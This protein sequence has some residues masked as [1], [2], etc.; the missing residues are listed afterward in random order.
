MTT[1]AQASGFTHGYCAECG[2]H[3]YVG[4]LH[5]ERGGPRCCLLC[6]GK[7]DAEHTPRR[8]ARRGLIRALK[9]YD[10]A[11]GNVYGREFDELKLLA[12]SR[13]FSAISEDFKDLTTELLTA[14]LALTHPDRH[15]PERNAEAQRVT[16]ELTALQPFVFPA[17]EPE[18][19]P[20]PPPRSEP[21]SEPSLSK[22][23]AYPCED[24]RGTVAS[25]Y[26]DACS[27]EH[28]KRS[29]KDFEQRT[30]KQRAQYARR[31]ERVLARRRPAICSI[32]RKEFASRRSDARFCSDRCRQQAH[33]QAPV[34]HKHQPSRKLSTTRD[35]WKRAILALLDRH[36]AVYLN[37]LLP[38]NRTR[39]Q[40]QQLCRVVAELEDHGEIETLTYWVRWDRPGH[41]ALIKPGYTI[42]DRQV[43]LLEDGERLQTTTANQNQAGD[44]RQQ[45]SP[46]HRAA[47]AAMEM[48]P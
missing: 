40:Y 31:R 45:A 16:Q 48:V 19:P 24:C 28:E 43:A 25:L 14:A 13:F 6:I 3:D 8:R 12:T 4:P 17:P 2:K 42:K 23:L 21:R 37:D 34:T 46:C 11:G 22:L 7:W 26:C 20:E 33:R 27:A 32:C 15:P 10:A 36:S 9:A 41:K 5:G 38:E 30:A 29:Q 1:H 35:G 39:A 47:A 18:P 44:E